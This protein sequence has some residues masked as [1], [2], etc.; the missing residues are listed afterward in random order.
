[1]WKSF[2]EALGIQTVVNEPTSRKVLEDGAA[3]VADE[4]CLPLK[5]FFGH[6]QALIGAC[7]YILVPHVSNFGRQ[8]G[9]PPL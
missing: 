9:K 6:I 2:S 3:L 4:S 8:R 5:I 1:L 7:D